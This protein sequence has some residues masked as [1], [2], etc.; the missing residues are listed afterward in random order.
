MSKRKQ[1][2]SFTHK[3]FLV[4]LHEQEGIFTADI[5]DSRPGMMPV[6]TWSLNT[7]APRTV[8]EAAAGA[9]H[10]INH[11]PRWS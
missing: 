5:H 6:V 1:V 11:P 8:K 7:F 3:G 9:R 2:Q 4:E 10:I